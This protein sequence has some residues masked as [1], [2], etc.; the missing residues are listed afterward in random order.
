MTAWTS[1][2]VRPG[3]LG[4]PPASPMKAVRYPDP[5]CQFLHEVES[6]PVDEIPKALGQIESVRAVLYA[7]LLSRPAPPAAQESE[8]LL[9]AEEVAKRLGQKVAW[10]RRHKHQIGGLDS[11]SRHLRF[12][13]VEVNRYVKRVSKN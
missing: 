1:D 7:R 3:T 4:G 6:V 5:I 11:L 12:R 13:E 2:G 10:V 9:R 8:R